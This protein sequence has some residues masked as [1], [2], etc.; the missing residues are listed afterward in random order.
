MRK[1]GILLP[2]A[3]V[4][5]AYGIG[6]L[7]K[8][9]F[10]F[11]DFLQ[12][13]GQGIWQ[14]L[15]LSPTGFGDSP[16]QSCSAFAGN[17]YFIDP[18][19]LRKDGL[20]TKAECEAEAKRYAHKTR[21]DYALLYQTRFTLLRAAFAR[22]SAWYP[23][24]Y[25]HFCYEQGWWL[26][27]YALYMTAKGLNGG[28]SYR[29]W[30][31]EAQRLHKREAIDKLYAE[32][33]KEVHF[34][35]FCQYEFARQWHAL[36]GYAK[37]QGVSILGDI[38]IY[39]AADSADVWAAPELFDLDETGAPRSVAG[40]PPDAFSDDGQLWGNPLYDWA[41]HER[42]QY[43][44]WVKRIR[45]ALS[46]YDTLRIDHFRGFDTYYAIPAN[47]KTAQEGEWRQGPGM[48]LFRA[49]KKELGSAP[50]VAE[51]LGELFPSVYELLKESG[52]P[53]MKVMQFAFGCENSEYQPH[54][55]PEHCVVYT[56]T[57]DNTTAEA[58]YRTAPAKEKRLAK[59]YLNLTAEEGY[60]M[61]LVRGALA[62]PGE[63]CVIP[64][65]D[66]LGLGV[67]ARINAPSTL[68]GKNWTWRAPA[69]ALNGQTARKIAA[70]VKR[71]GR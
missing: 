54:N 62:S 44:W 16:Y 3:S 64:L 71:Y 28:K 31:D 41:Y 5:G 40:C 15:P 30:D 21:I 43:A 46:L 29:E 65:A 70:L 56:G 59:Q 35:K 1:S 61:G 47:A 36:H 37:E 33:E 49:V 7:G 17:P 45:Y 66:Y 2:V 13:A 22:F 20:L 57:H 18:D 11:V 69:E 14:M 19:L 55:H 4:P 10:Q 67:E 38:P 27:D 68:G 51:D 50:I 34:W 48:K 52:F 42:T 39:V 9:A 25:Y 53:G 63:T 32:H 24:D 23:D 12:R 58:W 8:P 60:G 6:T 26:E